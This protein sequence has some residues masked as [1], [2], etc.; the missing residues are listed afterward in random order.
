MTKRVNDTLLFVS[1]IIPE[2]VWT[3]RSKVIFK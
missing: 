1:E 3:G 2:Q